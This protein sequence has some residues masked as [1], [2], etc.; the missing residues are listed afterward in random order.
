MVNARSA[1][2]NL[3]HKKLAEYER[4]QTQKLL[5]AKFNNMKL[6]WKMLT[7]NNTPKPTPNI[8]NLEYKDYFMKLGDPGDEFFTP[9]S[10][11]T[12]NVQSILDNDLEY[13]FD[14][15]NVK[16]TQDELKNSIKQL[17]PGGRPTNV[18]RII[19]ISQINLTAM[20]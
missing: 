13:A 6:Y 20:S 14:E 12:R 10:D 9:D 11:V 7:N 4:Q 18:D 15:L 1:Y 8:S 3:C 19:V 5:N 16:I 17:K 2:K